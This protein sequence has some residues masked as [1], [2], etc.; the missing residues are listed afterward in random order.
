M[1]PAPRNIQQRLEDTHRRL[2]TDV[3]AW[4]ATADAVTGSPY[5]VPLSFW[6]D[7]RAIF[8][9]TL[10]SS[11]TGRNLTAGGAA[12]VG[13]GTTRDVVL[14]DGTAQPVPWDELPPGVADAFAAKTG[15][16]VRPLAPTY[17]FFRIDPV[18]VQAWRES[19]ELAGRDLMRAGRWLT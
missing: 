5:L 8:V 1:K 18:S 14:M 9:A 2:S 3:D 13:I 12:R 17:L 7:G 10:E 6:W 15:F 11:P 4:V 16:E 19:N